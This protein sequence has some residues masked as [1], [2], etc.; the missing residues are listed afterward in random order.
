MRK[1]LIAA[2]V[3]CGAA[4]AARA[5]SFKIEPYL[6]N[7]SGTSM[8]VCWRTDVLATSTVLYGATATQLTP[9]TVPGTTQQHEVTLSGLAPGA[10]YY[11]KVQS[12]AGTTIESALATLTTAG[13]G[14]K[15]RFAFITD[16]QTDPSVNQSFTDDLIDFGPEMLFHG[17]DHVDDGDDI[18]GEW[19]AYFASSKGYLSVKP[20]F[21]VMGNHNYRTD[22]L[23]LGHDHAETS[24][25]LFAQPGN[26]RW[27]TVRRGTVLFIVLDANQDRYPQVQTVEPGWLAQVLQDATDGVDDP[28]LKIA[29]FH[30]PAF[31]SGIH[32][33]EFPNV[34]LDD[35]FVMDNFVPLFEQYGV[36]LVLNGHE[37]F[38]ERSRKAAIP[39]LICGSAGGTTRGQEGTNP[40]SELLVEYANTVFLA[41]VDVNRVTLDVVRPDGSLIETVVVE[42]LAIR[43]ETLPDAVKGIPYQAALDTSGGQAP[44]T[45]ALLSGT[46][47]PG[48]TFDTATGVFA[49]TPTTLGTFPFR[50]RVTDQAGKSHERDLAIRVVGSTVR[51]VSGPGAGSGNPPLVGFFDGNGAAIGTTFQ[52]YGT[53][54]WGANVAAANIWT[55]SDDEVI[56]GPGPGPQFGPQLRGFLADG[57]PI[58]KVNGFV[59]GTLRYGANVGAASVDG[60]AWAEILTGPGP[61]SIF[62]PH[63]RGFSVDG[64]G[65]APIGGINA[66][67]YATLRYGVNVSAGDVEGDAFAEIVVGAGPGTVFGPHVRG[68]DF[69]GGPLRSMASINHF[70]FGTTSYG[71]NVGAG[72]VDGDA[73][74]EVLAAKG[75]GASFDSGWR[76][77]IT[78]VRP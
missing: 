66:F 59:Y 46:L 70:V 32:T 5:L 6:Q 1:S 14:S 49:G 11:Y 48:V 75:P 41:D 23:G 16:T 34:E 2:L 67:A 77:S 61:G 38:Y 76:A 18:D 47:P 33:L 35:E 12:Q 68:F 57:T 36:S 53:S 25:L 60:D 52:A 39:Y 62:G 13:V 19:L 26:E 27:F 54:A 56:T 69:D 73:M 8:V 4:P 71:V 21:S 40:Y 31:S 55:A 58:A 45:Y 37:H 24:I 17:G 20:Q 65:L 78:M 42:V 30:Q 63:L 44:Y 72:D 10:T 50:V 29:C 3:L 9:V 74:D 28:L 15:F 7:Q 22:P 43:T 64:V 51:I